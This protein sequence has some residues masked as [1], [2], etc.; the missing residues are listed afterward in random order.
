MSFGWG[1]VLSGGLNTIGSIFNTNLQYRNAVDQARFNTRTLA[2]RLALEMRN[3][4]QSIAIQRMNNAAMVAAARQNAAAQIRS[5]QEQERLI[6]NER[7]RQ[8]EYSRGQRDAVD[9]NIG[10]FGDFTGQMGGKAEAITDALMSLIDSK[11]MP[12]NGMPAASGAVAAREAAMREQA[13]ADVADGVAR[14]A[15]LQSMD[16]L[17]GDIGVASNRNNQIS[18]LLGNFA[19]GSAAVLDPALAAAQMVFERKPIMRQAVQERYIQPTFNGR[20]NMLGDLLQVG[21]QFM[22]RSGLDDRLAGLFRPSP[23]SLSGAG[24]DA[25]L[26]LPKAPNLDWMG[27]G[28]GLR[29]GGGNTGLVLNSNLGIR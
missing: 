15:D 10:L 29:L 25:G 18:G 4:E 20:T 23:Y 27:G 19:Q 12:A 28:Q 13:S 5:I 7:G 1:D 26:K 14:G 21:A 16:E 2:E 17:L 22:N 3:L 11:E 8:Q 6:G 24:S 9:A